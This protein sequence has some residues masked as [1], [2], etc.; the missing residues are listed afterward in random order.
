MADCPPVKLLLLSDEEVRQSIEN[1][2]Q[3]RRY[4][5]VLMVD[6]LDDPEEG[7]AGQGQACASTSKKSA[8][9]D[10]YVSSTPVYPAF[11]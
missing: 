11:K 6:V 7:Q 3:Q 8:A 2:E 1:L 10:P 5:G 4:A 9:S